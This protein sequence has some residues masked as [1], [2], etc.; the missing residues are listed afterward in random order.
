M[1]AAQRPPGRGGAETLG[2]PRAARAADALAAVSSPR[3]AAPAPYAAALRASPQPHDPSLQPLALLRPSGLRSR[4]VISVLPAP[5]RRSSAPCPPTAGSWG[6]H[7]A[8]QQAPRGS[9]AEAPAGAG[10]AE[11]A[12]A[13]AAAEL[14]ALV[15]D[16]AVRALNARAGLERARGLADWM[17]RMAAALDATPPG[18]RLSEGLLRRLCTMFQDRGPNP[19]MLATDLAIDLV[20]HLGASAAEQVGAAGGRLGCSLG[21]AMHDCARLPPFGA[22][23]L[24]CF[25]GPADAW[26]NR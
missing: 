14:E 7:P 22:A 5:G 16:A 17:L 4:L 11:A 8:Q 10:G 19:A 13:A 26:H 20:N 9:M 23:Q 24:A 3:T 21:G 15:S 25:T 1:A 6:S 12:A 18:L 2:A